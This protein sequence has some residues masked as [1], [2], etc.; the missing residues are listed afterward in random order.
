MGWID[1]KPEFLAQYARAREE[2][3]AKVALR[4]PRM[5]RLG[6]GAS[7]ERPEFSAHYAREGEDGT[8]GVL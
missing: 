3:D 1:A 2:R 8:T 7:T 6:Q 5:A 4:E